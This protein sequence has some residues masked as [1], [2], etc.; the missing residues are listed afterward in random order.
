MTTIT[1]NYIVLQYIQNQYR[2][3]EITQ[4]FMLLILII[5][6]YGICISIYLYME[7]WHI[8]IIIIFFSNSSRKT[9]TS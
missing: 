9:N 7:S 6:L 4:H 8:I 1:I 3:I 2:Y 5:L